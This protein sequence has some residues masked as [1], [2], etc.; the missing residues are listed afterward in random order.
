MEVKNL[1]FVT[2]DGIRL[3]DRISL[4]LKP[5][6][7]MALVGFSGS[8]KS[9]LAQCVGQLYSYTDGQVLLG[10]AEVQELTKKDMAQN[11]GF[12]SQTRL[13]S[14]GRSKKTCCTPAA[15]RGMVRM[16]LPAGLIRP[17]KT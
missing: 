14:P 11:M 9:T 10:N 7:H 12:I 15:P 4:E 3:L 13:S 2:G 16:R 17:W 8:G 1:A 5:G 6:E